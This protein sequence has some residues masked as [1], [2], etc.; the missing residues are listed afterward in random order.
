MYLFF[1]Y[2]YITLKIEKEKRLKRRD[3]KNCK[4]TTTFV[5]ECEK[6]LECKKNEILNMGYKQELLLEKSKEPEK[7]NEINKKWTT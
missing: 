2:S 5:K 7:F 1:V 3:I 4:E 6:N